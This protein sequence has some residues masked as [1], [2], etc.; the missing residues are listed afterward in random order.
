MKA[1]WALLLSALS[2]VSEGEFLPPDMIEPGMRG[3]GL[4]VFRGRG[5]DTFEVEALGVLKDW[6]PKM[7]LILVRLSGGPDGVL[8]KA[9]VIAGMSG[10]PIFLGGKLAG[11]V[12]YGW[13][14]S[15]EPICGVTPIGAMLEVAR[16]PSNVPDAVP[17]RKELAPIATP[18]WLSGFSPSLVSEM[19]DAL[20]RFGMLPVSG[21]ASGSHAADSLSPGSALGVQLVRGDVSATAIG[22]LTWVQ[23]DT[24]LAFGHPMFSSGST[25]LPMTGAYIYDVLPSVYRSFKIGAATGPTG[26][27]LQDRLPAIAGVRGRRPDMLPVT[28]EVGGKGFRFEVVRHPRMG[29]F[30]VVYGLASIVAAA[31]KASGESTVRLE[32]TLFLRS[33]LPDTMKV[34]DLFSGFGAPL[35][36]ARSIG[37]LLSAVME[38]PFREVRVDSASFHVQVEEKVKLAWIEGVRVDRQVV[39]PGEDLR[40][41]VFLRRYLGGRDTLAFDLELPEDLGEGQVVLRVGDATH[42]ERWEQERAPGRFVPMDL[43]QLLQ[44]LGES[45]PNDR[46]YVELVAPR[47]GLTVSGAELQRLPPSALSVLK[48]GRQTATSQPVRETLLLERESPVGAVVRGAHTV[49]LR[50]ER[51]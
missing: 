16:R 9:G 38:N 28:V 39:R 20:E 49:E 7:D 31:E 1:I 14:F 36:A 5:V 11:A 34:R 15:K 40:V 29:P 33:T 32:G 13:P 44:R 48:P 10:S 46:V 37:W 18:L 2:G 21:G 17:D 50:V 47:E 12:A 22:T 4:T 6:A 24:V 45:K 27:I 23:G 3:F 19:R 30:F 25:A 8:G 43:F 26:V 42:I 51:R 41:E 35:Q